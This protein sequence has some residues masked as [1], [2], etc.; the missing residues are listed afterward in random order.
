MFQTPNLRHK[1]SRANQQVWSGN[2]SGNEQNGYSNEGHVGG[3]YLP[4]SYY[5]YEQ[6]GKGWIDCSWRGHNNQPSAYEWRMNTPYCDQ[7]ESSYPG[8]SSLTF[9]ANMCADIGVA[10]NKNSS[11]QNRNQT[12]SISPKNIASKC[13]KFGLFR[14]PHKK[15]DWDRLVDDIFTDEIAKLSDQVQNNISHVIDFK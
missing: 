8:P 7:D 6:K 15:V 14:D 11:L 10:K 3:I 9:L 5:W 13:R 4:K 1:K 2:H 12:L